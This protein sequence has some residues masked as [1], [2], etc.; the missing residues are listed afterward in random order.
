MTPLGEIVALPERGLFMG[1]RGC[2]HDGASSDAV[3]VP[4][5]LGALETARLHP[6][7]V[8][9]D[10]SLVELARRG[11]QQQGLPWEL[12]QAGGVHLDRH[13]P[14][15]LAM[16]RWPRAARDD[17]GPSSSLRAEGEAIQ[18]AVAR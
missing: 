13:A 10:T 3:V 7:F 4:A 2:L 16:T 8:T 6:L 5:E 11:Y 1:N 18:V 12:P 14:S 9:A 15:G 17:A